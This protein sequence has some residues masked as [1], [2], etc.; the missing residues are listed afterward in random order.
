MRLLTRYDQRLISGQVLSRAVN[1]EPS[2]A[3]CT[4]NQNMFRRARR[5]FALVVAGG[6]KPANIRQGQGA[7][8][9]MRPRPLQNRA[10]HNMHDFARETILQS[11]RL[12]S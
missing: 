8:Q 9:G 2:L 4:V 1:F 11:Q 5:S 12:H 3:V 10:G 6:R 7:D